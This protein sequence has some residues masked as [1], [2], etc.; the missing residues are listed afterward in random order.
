MHYK[1]VRLNVSKSQKHWDFEKME[2]TMRL[3]C[4]EKTSFFEMKFFQK[5]LQNFLW[6]LRIY[7]RHLKG[8]PSL[9]LCVSKKIVTVR[10]T[11]P[12]ILQKMSWKGKNHAFFPP[13]VQDTRSFARLV[14]T[15]P[16]LGRM[17]LFDSGCFI[18]RHKVLED[19]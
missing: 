4:F 14:I 12:T 2:L 10:H 3:E 9:Y 7:S 11:N 6:T 8:P 19:F 17:G 1:P 13:H 15:P 18:S 5:R 16:F